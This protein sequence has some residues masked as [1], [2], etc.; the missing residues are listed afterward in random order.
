MND[1]VST[2]WIPLVARRRR[3]DLASGYRGGVRV[4]TDGLSASGAS[5]ERETCYGVTPAILLL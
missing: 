4:Q 2:A 1:G 3:V 5:S